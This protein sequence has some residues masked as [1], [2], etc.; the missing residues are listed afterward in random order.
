MWNLGCS[1]TLV[2]W[3]LQKILTEAYHHQLRS[4]GLLSYRPLGGARRDPGWVWS[5]VFQNLGDNK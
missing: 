4:Q 3:G 2:F 5:R 1:I